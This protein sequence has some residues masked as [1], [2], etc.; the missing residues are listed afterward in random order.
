MTKN[1]D[2]ANQAR[3]RRALARSAREHG[4]S[5]H[6]GA[7]A[8]EASKWRRIALSL[9]ALAT[10][11][12][13]FERSPIVHEDAAFDLVDLFCGCGGTSVGFAAISQLGPF[14][15]LASALD[16]DRHATAS[17][18]VNL[19]VKPL[20]ADIAQLVRER[21]ALRNLPRIFRLRPDH[22]LI[23]IGCAPCQGFSAHRKKDKSAKLDWR[24]SLVVDFAEVALTLKPEV[25]F[26]ENVPELLSGRYRAFYEAAES[27]LAKAGYVLQ[28]RV[29]NM[30]EFG[31]PQKRYRAVVLGFR[32]P[33]RMIEGFL[34]PEKFP[35]VREAIG[36]L[37]AIQ[38][39]KAH[40][41]DPM[42]V[43]AR[44]RQA[45][46]DVIRRVPKNGGSRP[47]GVGPKC[48]DRVKGFYDVYGR[49]R[50]DKPA[51]TIT[52]Y[53]RNPASGR[54]VHPTQDRGLSIREAALL[55]GF[56][57]RHQFVGPFDDR[58]A[59]IGN[60]VPPSFAAQV[61]AYIIG[62]L[63]SFDLGYRSLPEPTTKT[64]SLVYA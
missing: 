43:T 9:G 36:G 61:A 21:G 30:A 8:P 49:L 12:A 28:S 25:I 31:L 50:W 52:A 37:P 17:Y 63:A 14:F 33:F 45:T 46:I 2:F 26:M 19:G 29:V 1:F 3:I 41:S 16:I 4:L 44:H 42:H 7:Q 23:L 18:E 27:R 38:A 53:A 34:K 62:E 39:G 35:T 64:R 6:E 5:S 60:A 56:P 58:Y 59:Q 11:P 57:R 51:I 40:P 47:R 54:Y 24:N 32:R 10:S 55:Q 13:I 48:L 22:P 15:R 20:C